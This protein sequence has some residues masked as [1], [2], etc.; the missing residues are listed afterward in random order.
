MIRDKFSQVELILAKKSFIP[1]EAYTPKTMEVLL[2]KIANRND[3]I[4]LLSPILINCDS[5][6]NCK[7]T[8]IDCSEIIKY[9]ARRDLKKQEKEIIL[10]LLLTN[11]NHWML[12][13]SNP[14]TNHHYVVNTFAGFG[15]SAIKSAA[16]I[17]QTL[18]FDTKNT[19]AIAAFNPRDDK[20]STKPIVEIKETIAEI[21][22]D[23]DVRRGNIK[24][25]NHLALG[26]NN[27]C[28]PLIAEMSAQIIGNFSSMSE[29]Q[30][31]ATIMSVTQNQDGIRQKHAENVENIS[32]N[33]AKER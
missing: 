33:E 15:E 18:E 12:S 32:K 14:K 7:S 4:A 2:G 13:V 30:I 6:L 8:D 9:K 22:P 19:P 10:S 5:D 23:A 29:A 16:K 1:Q 25:Q 26:E 20:I 28:G 24:P 21:L 17:A 11:N 31:I 27:Y 3:K